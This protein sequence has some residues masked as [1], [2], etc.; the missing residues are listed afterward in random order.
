MARHPDLGARRN[1][2]IAVITSR[3]GIDEDRLAIALGLPLRIKRKDRISS[4]GRPSEGRS[5]TLL[6]LIKELEAAG[7][8]RCERATFADSREPR[9]LY[10]AD[11]QAPQ[12]QLFQ[13]PQR[14]DNLKIFKPGDPD[15]PSLAP[16]PERPTLKRSVKSLLSS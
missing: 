11:Y 9:K 15:Y 2:A 1:R 6:T 7:V 14:R 13:P 8:I 4:D 16:E 3:P 5:V 12:K 10:P